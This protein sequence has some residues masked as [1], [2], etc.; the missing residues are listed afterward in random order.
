MN[1]TPQ[2]GL[3]CSLPHVGTVLLM[4]TAKLYDVLVVKGYWTKGS[5]RKLFNSIGMLTSC[6]FMLT[7]PFMTDNLAKAVV[8]GLSLTSLQLAV[9]A[10]FY[11]SHSD[12]AGPFAGILFGLT[13]SFAQL[14]GILAPMMAADL[15]PNVSLVAPSIQGQ[16]FEQFH[17]R[18]LQRNGRLSF[19][20]QQPLA[21]LA[22]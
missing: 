10:G 18:A 2:N 15:A 19:C 22:H 6:M 1:I 4:P 16:T 21:S 17:F 13:N 20:P 8:L 7:I 11:I 3:L 5:L 9:S 14:P 12:V